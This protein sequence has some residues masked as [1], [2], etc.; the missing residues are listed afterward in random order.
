MNRENQPLV[1]DELVEV[2]D[3]RKLSD[4][5]GGIY[6]KCLKLHIKTE[7]SQHVTRWT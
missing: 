3:F 4:H 2:Q 6:G 5:F 7:R 1:A